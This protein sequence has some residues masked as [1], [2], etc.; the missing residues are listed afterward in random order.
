MIK[1]Y[2][3]LV[4]GSPE[5]TAIR[6]GLLTASEMKFIITPKKLA[7]AQNDKFNAHLYELAA[8]RVT[9]YVEPHYIS[10]DML[11][12]TGDE[13]EA[14]I[15]YNEKIAPL[16]NC[17]FIT[18]DKFGFTLGYSPDALVGDEGLIECKSRRQKFQMQTIT[19]KEMPDDFKI[20]VQTGML[21]SGRPWCDFISYCG[22]MPMMPLRVDADVSI[23]GPIIEAAKFFHE[24]LDMVLE[25]YAK[26][27][28]AP[29]SRLIPTVRKIEQEII[30]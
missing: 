25:R 15:I 27:L 19:D 30:L 29:D 11:R 21:V 22:G 16:Q 13:M 14:K 26:R 10:D 9:Q 17:G 24:C 28:A 5:W 23:Q 7:V 12:G 6:C 2:E 4:Q 18:N 3:N 8:Q 20:Q 1:Y